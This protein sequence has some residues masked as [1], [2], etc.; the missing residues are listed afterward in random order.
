M[1]NFHLKKL[2][3]NTWLGLG[4]DHILVEN[5][6]FWTRGGPRSRY[7][8]RDLSAQTQQ[9]N[10]QFQTYKHLNADSNPGRWLGCL[11]TANP[12]TESH[13]ISTQCQC[14]TTQYVQIDVSTK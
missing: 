6:C 9:E 7:G 12:S 11:I 10:I 4:K 13:V 5:T 3:R 8:H 14:D 1:I 2:N